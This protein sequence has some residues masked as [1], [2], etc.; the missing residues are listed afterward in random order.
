MK[1]ADNI[2]IGVSELFFKQNIIA[3]FHLYYDLRKDKCLL[4]IHIII[5]Q[6]IENVNR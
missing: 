5:H 3:I 1:I 2:I 6:L 4:T